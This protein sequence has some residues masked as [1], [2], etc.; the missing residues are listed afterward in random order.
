MADATP[1]NAELAEV[2]LNRE[3]FERLDK[4][5]RDYVLDRLRSYDKLDKL[6]QITELIKTLES[7]RR[8]DAA[9]VLA[10]E[11]NRKLIIDVIREYRKQ[12]RAES[13]A[14]FYRKWTKK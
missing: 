12:D 2:G 5:D 9:T 4:D 11:Q 7:E 10:S 1:T 14:E 3:D 13:V 6:Y 8:E